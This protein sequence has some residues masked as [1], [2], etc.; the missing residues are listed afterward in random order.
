MA[1]AFLA[2]GA[3]GATAEPG[4]SWRPLL[5]DGEMGAG[6][7]KAE[8]GAWGFDTSGVDRAEQPGDSF[9]KYANG[10]WLAR[11]EIPADKTSIGAFNLL[12]DRSE[13]QLRDLIQAD[14][15]RKAPLT[16]NAG[17]VGAA[18]TAFMD[19]A[20][21][22]KLDAA[23]LK[24]ELARIAAIHDK[25]HM[26]AYMGRSH[27]H[28]GASI[29]RAG[30]SEDEK[31]P[32]FHTLEIGTAGL[33]LPDRDYYLSPNFAAKKAK[34]RDYVARMLSM[35]GW[36]NADKSADEIVAFETRLAQASWTRAE[37]R[38]PD[39]TYN[40]MTRR[41]LAASSPGF[42]WEA[43]FEGAG[44]AKVDHVI[45]GENT[46]F[47]KFAAIFAET[48][49]ETLK[50]WE[51]FRL[52]DQSAPLLSK[53]F[54]D[55][56]FD[57]RS[58][59]LG[60]QPLQRPRWK[61]AV[62]VTNFELGEAL[63]Q[64]YV[65]T[66]FPPESKVKMDQLVRELRLA[67]HGRIERLTWMTP[68]TKAKALEKLDHF[69][70]KIGYPVKWRDYSALVVR[71]DDALGNARRAGLFEWNWEVS[72]L[73]KPVDK[74]EWGMTPQ[75]V[76]AYYSPTRNEIV[77]PAAILQAPFFDPHADAAVNYGGI[78]S[79]IGHEMTHGFDDEGRKFDGTGRLTDWWSAAD[80]QKF[81]AQT[82]KYGAQFDTY[83]VAPGV[84]VKGA[85]TMGE[86]I[87]DLGGLL[88]ALDA[89]HASLKGQPAPVLD[90]WTGD[91]RVFLGQAQV[92]RQ[93][94]RLDALKQQTVVD[95]HSPAEF[96]VNGPVRNI[97]AW[98]EA[99]GVK[100]GDKLYLKPEHRVRIW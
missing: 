57:F 3:S 59:E 53:R 16:T 56:Q 95:V 35:A 10:A 72:K 51:A 45:V 94:A 1:A 31:N 36:P 97:D 84:H 39:K 30:V 77:F 76:N 64:E 62:A 75:T 34:Y 52:T 4:H 74:D 73:G 21:I 28:A 22:E 41:E 86:N 89:Y 7:A 88:V 5:A 55:A 85:Q 49:L 65:K 66:Y 100:P 61:R 67:L 80:G 70:V 40:P 71:P 20:R 50:A 92:W 68:Q 12:A 15:A 91:Q 47:P 82:A 33:G 87:A 14:A 78:G 99:F 13:L 48:P 9:F 42:G 18:W 63:G 19:E 8:L 37:R 46:S 69:G 6:P 58:R 98:Y 25:G 27:G 83:E 96:R 11:T 32:G 17:K 93:K 60:G 23:P 43:F 29:F 44:L 81:D 26:A 90:G 54:S 2:M 38:N 79:V 24:P